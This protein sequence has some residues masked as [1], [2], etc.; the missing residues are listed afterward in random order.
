MTN[1]VHPIIERVRKA[2]ELREERIKE[3]IKELEK[4][5]KSCDAKSLKQAYILGEERTS[6]ED[7]RK[8][9]MLIAQFELDCGCTMKPI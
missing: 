8:I 2:A 7:A 3:R 1:S 6:M 9:S 5:V 4:S